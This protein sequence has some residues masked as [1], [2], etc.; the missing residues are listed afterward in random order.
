MKNKGNLDDFSRHLPSLE[1]SQA[2][3]AEASVTKS[4]ENKADPIQQQG[5]TTNQ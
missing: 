4:E 5:K 1:L 3:E 2:A